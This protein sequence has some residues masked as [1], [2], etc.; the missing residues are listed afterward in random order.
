MGPTGT[1]ALACLTGGGGGTIRDVLVLEVPIVLRRE[2]YA[3]AGILGALPFSLP[4]Q[5]GADRT[6]AAGLCAVFVVATRLVCVWKQ[7]DLPRRAAGDG[8]PAAGQ[9][10]PAS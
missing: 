5:A 1:T 7:V 9:D 4:A 3:G 6:P 2:V 10:Q 8:D